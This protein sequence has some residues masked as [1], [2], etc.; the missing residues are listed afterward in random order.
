MLKAQGTSLASLG[1]GQPGGPAILGPDG[2]IPLDE[3]PIEVWAYQ[4]DWDVATNDPSL[5][6][7]VGTLGWTYLVSTG[8]TRDTG[9]GNIVWNIGDVAVYDGEQWD[10]IPHGGQFFVTVG[11]QSAASMLVIGT[12]NAQPFRII[13]N[14]FPRVTVSSI[15]N[16]GIGVD[17]PTVPLH[18][19]GAIA[20]VAGSVQTTWDPT[21]GVA[22]ALGTLSNHPVNLV[23]GGTTRCTIAANGDFQMATGYTPVAARSVATKEYVDAHSGVGGTYTPTVTPGTNVASATANG[24]FIYSRDGTSVQIAGSLDVTATAPGA[25]VVQIS[26][27]VAPGAPFADTH[28]LSGSGAATNGTVMSPAYLRSVSGQSAAVIDWVAPNTQLNTLRFNAM[29]TITP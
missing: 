19:A 21:S 11:G 4:G 7:G 23:A 13:T 22:L 2:K 15:G 14:N 16:V 18:I 24:D 28:K 8:G 6:D 10:Q 1:G 25:A 20:V 17:V 9:H 3:M 26:L 5:V 12:T 29:Y 27:P